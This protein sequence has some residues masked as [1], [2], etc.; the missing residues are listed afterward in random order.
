[1]KT[2]ILISLFWTVTLIQKPDPKPRLNKC[3]LTIE[4]SPEV[5]GL[6]LGQPYEALTNLG[7]DGARPL[8]SGENE[9]GLR[10]V[11]LVNYLDRSDR[12][13]GIDRVTLQYLEGSLVSFEMQYDYKVKWQSDAHFAAANC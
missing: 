9:V 3:I 1:M 11:Y 6:K 12:L 13:K 8:D 4:Q 5:R 10:R 7:N 2:L